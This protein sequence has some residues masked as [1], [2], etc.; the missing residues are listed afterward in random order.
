MTQMLYLKLEG[1]EGEEPIGDD[2]QD[3]IAI[4]DYSHSIHRE[5]A[6]VR[7]S[8][9]AEATRRRSAG[10]HAPFVVHKAFD[11]TSPRLFAAAVAGVV[12]KHA[13]VYSCSQDVS[14]LTG[15]SKPLPFLTIVL[16]NAVIV[17]FNYSY[18]GSWQMERIAFDYETIAWQADWKDPESGDSETLEPVG[19]EGSKNKVDNTDPPSSVEWET[20]LL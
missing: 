19:W 8:A 16:K 2:S 14:A 1:V 15:S 10:I 4:I 9:G 5:M 11:K 13:V 17:D 12:F 3:A 18:E 6:A 7:P 20:G